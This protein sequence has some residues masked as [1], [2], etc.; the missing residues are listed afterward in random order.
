MSSVKPG[1]LRRT[2]SPIIGE[3]ASAFI[4]Q[5]T[6][7]GDILDDRIH[8]VSIS[9]GTSGGRAAGSIPATLEVD[10]KGQFSAAAA[11]ANVRFLLRSAAAAK[12]AAHLNTDAAAIQTRYTGRLGQTEV[13]DTGRRFSTV[14]RA[15]SWITQM[16]YSP[17]HSAGQAGQPLNTVLA[18]LMAADQPLRGIKA[19][20]YPPFD[21]LAVT[22]DPMLFKDGIQRYATDL[23]TLLQ[24]T[25]DGR[26]R[27]L[28]LLNRMGTAN[29]N[30]AYQLP[31]TRSQAIS[32]ARWEQSN[33]RPAIKV[34]Y[35]VRDATG[36]ISTRT[37]E[38]E[39]P[40]GELVETTEADWSYVRVADVD[41]GPY[42]EAYARVYSSNNRQFS[43]PS[44]T[45]DLLRLISSPK[46]YH[47]DQAAQL[48]ALEHGEP[49]YFSADW[50]EPL[51][52]VHFAEGITETINYQE[53]KLEL[54]LV[55]Y[56]QA[57]GDT[58]SPL[59]P[60][61]VWDSAGN[62]WNNETMRWIDA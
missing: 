4:L 33:Q 31:L 38:V 15:A 23:G 46:Q 22:E 12:L 62:T 26:T 51:R 39:N 53:W 29:Q 58:P 3:T 49:V 44:V 48:L 35:T 27:V 18:G 17:R 52:G 50:P 54:S 21:I 55:P 45:V 6:P 13:N 60:P 24:E 16:N 32:P 14:Y 19:S 20:F 10:I 28:P 61:K 1:R 59:V 57:V 25:R 56:A 7:L 47:R 9:R 34:R 36:A 42:R 8:T 5:S 2:L 11:G 43:V 37:A 41:S 40:T 30:P